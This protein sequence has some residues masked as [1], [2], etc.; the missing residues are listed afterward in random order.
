MAC[1]GIIHV[2]PGEVDQA[3][4]R[5]VSRIPGIERHLFHFLLQ[6]RIKILPGDEQCGDGNGRRIRFLPFDIGLLN[7]SLPVIDEKLNAKLETDIPLR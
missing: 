5:K 6:L 7:G 2:F 3:K 4:R 1:A